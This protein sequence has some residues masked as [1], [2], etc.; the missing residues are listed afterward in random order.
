MKF[1]PDI[2]I[3]MHSVSSLKPGVTYIY[4]TTEQQLCIFQSVS[5]IC[6]REKG[7]WYVRLNAGAG[8]LVRYNINT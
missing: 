3:V 6:I 4:S 5:T 2:H 1:D 7:K 8:P